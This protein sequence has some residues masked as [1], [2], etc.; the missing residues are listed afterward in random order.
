MAN[1]KLIS[2][3]I[4]LG[5]LEQLDLETRCTGRARNF[6]INR[7]CRDYLEL[8]DIIRRCEAMRES[9]KDSTAFNNWITRVRGFMA[10]YRNGELKSNVYTNS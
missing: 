4:D 10:H 9:I 1:Q 6:M 2:V 5:V 3:R 8:I 7:S